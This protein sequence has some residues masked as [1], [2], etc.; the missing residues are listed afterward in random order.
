MITLR[1]DKMASRVASSVLGAA[2]L[3]ELVTDTFEGISI[4][5]STFDL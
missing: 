3:P 1:Q 5:I 4:Y 2:G